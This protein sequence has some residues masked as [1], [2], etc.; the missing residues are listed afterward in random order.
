MSMRLNNWWL[1]SSDPEIYFLLAKPNTHSLI[2]WNLTALTITAVFTLWF[3]G[4]SGARHG[5]PLPDYGVVPNFLLTERSGRA[6]S[7]LDLKDKVWIADFMFTRCSGVCPI[8][9]SR[10][11]GLQEKLKKCHFVSFTSDADYDTPARLSTYAD[12]TG[13]DKDR[14]W[15]LTG[16]KDVIN[17]VATGLKFSR[18]DEPAMHS[19]SFVLID[20][21]GH[22]RGYYDADDSKRIAALEKDAKQ[23]TGV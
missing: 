16:D 7:E 20:R 10:M 17:K 13:A 6:A 1:C 4:S 11:Y 12:M 9:A 19:A 2:F 14:W 18:I 22:V 21:N 15:F 8:M 5:A 23:L 3:V